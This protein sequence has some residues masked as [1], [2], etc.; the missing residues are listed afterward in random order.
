MRFSLGLRVLLLVM[1]AN[2]AVF[3]AGLVFLVER[4]SMEREEVSERF[5]KLLLYTLQ[6]TINPG[7][8]LKV[9]SILEWPWWGEFSDA[10][11]VDRNLERVESKELVPRGVFLNPLGAAHRSVDFDRGSV[12]EAIS[13]SMNTSENILASGGVAI[14]IY[15][16]SGE[17]WG[18]CWFQ[19]PAGAGPRELALDLLP[20]YL[21]NTLLLSAA[22]FWVLRRKVLGPVQDLA[23]ASARLSEGD[24]EV[25]LKVPSNSDEIADLVR[26][27]NDM[28]GEVTR[29][30]VHLEEVAADERAKARTAEEAAMTQRRL[31]AMGE[32]AAGIAHEINNPLGGMRSAVESLE[33]GDLDP[34]RRERYLQLVDGGLVRIQGIVGKLLRFTPRASVSEA[35]FELKEAVQ[36]AVALIE[37]RASSQGVSL[38]V[39]FDAA[40]ETKVQ[41][42]QSEIGQ[43]VLNLLQNSLDSLED[44]CRSGSPELRVGLLSQDGEHR[45]Q[46]EDNGPGVEPERLARLTDIFYT[47]KDVGR[48][49]GLGLPLALHVASAHGG[50]LLLSSEPMQ[51]FLAELCLPIAKEQK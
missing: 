13:S 41:G 33:R 47:S 36:D 35:P 1:A 40:G 50:R 16:R 22:T 6:G 25:R 11:L 7:G 12:L 39:Q 31:A 5:R 34:E 27:F 26:G 30:R 2:S 28:A 38:E 23:A 19:V 42:D 18:G 29:A 48:G 51:G 24:L 14:P 8:E 49:T 20:W 17:V 46:I 3:G 32:L 44:G 4:I 21:G 9:A 45:V 43:A 10:I 37:H 15:D